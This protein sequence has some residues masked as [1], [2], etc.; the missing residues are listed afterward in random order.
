MTKTRVNPDTGIIETQEGI[1][2]SI[3]DIWT[4]KQD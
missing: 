2:E 3:L 1:F 4:P